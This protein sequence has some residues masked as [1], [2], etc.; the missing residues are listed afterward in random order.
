MK[1]RLVY[2]IL[3]LIFIIIFLLA[4]KVKANLDL[5]W[6]YSDE[7]LDEL[8]N[9]KG[10]YIN[11]EKLALEVGTTLLYSAF[12]NNLIGNEEIELKVHNRDPQ[13]KWD[14]VWQVYADSKPVMTKH[15]Y[16]YFVGGCPYVVFKKNGEILEFGITE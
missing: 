1:K 15:G 16:E 5:N 13:C 9:T 3:F 12:P 8:N 7:H 6:E 14:N 11:D 2:I 4:Y 10:L